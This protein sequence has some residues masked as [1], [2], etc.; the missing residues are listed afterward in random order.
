MEHHRANCRN[1][2]AKAMPAG[3]A[4]NPFWHSQ[5]LV[6]C[7]NKEIC[8]YAFS[9]FPLK[10]SFAAVWQRRIREEQKLFYW[11]FLGL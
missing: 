8:G 9:C 11:K 7:K 3:S 10:R 5:W 1:S 4:K 2:I 6:V